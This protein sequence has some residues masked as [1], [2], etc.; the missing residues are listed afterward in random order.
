MYLFDVMVTCCA[1]R[2]VSRQAVDPMLSFEDVL[3]HFF[4]QG[5][6][7]YIADE[8]QRQVILRGV[9]VETEQRNIPA[10][11]DRPTNPSLY[12]GQC[13]SNNNVYQEPPTCEVDYGKGMYNISDEWD[14]HNDF[15]QI[16]KWGFVSSIQR[17]ISLQFSM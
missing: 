2:F 9:D 5:Y 4:C 7:G 15:A 12:D 1:P 6:Y 13:P 16:R 17:E 3:L 11:Q 10:D 8:Y 14:S